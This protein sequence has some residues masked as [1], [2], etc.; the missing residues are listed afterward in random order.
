ME[1]FE[2]WKNITK[3]SWSN[4]KALARLFENVSKYLQNNDMSQIEGMIII[5]SSIN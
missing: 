5:L 3:E 4:P 1:L 2:T